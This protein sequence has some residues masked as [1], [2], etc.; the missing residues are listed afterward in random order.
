MLVKNGLETIGAFNI[1]TRLRLQT[2][3][4]LGV[5]LAT[6]LAP[7]MG[8]TT[9]PI[10]L[11][12]LKT[13]E[14]LG[15]E[16]FARSGSTGMVLVV[17][18]DDQVF[19]HGYG[20]NAPQS[21][22]AP[23]S[24]SVVRIC[25]LTKIF[26]SDV[27]TKLVLDKTVRLEDPLQSYA[28]AHKVVPIRNKIITL[29][30]LAT[31]TSGLPR[32]VGSAPRHTPHFTF[33][34]RATR[35]R[36]LPNQYLR[37]TPGSEALYSNVGFDLLGD[38][39]AAAAHKQ[40][41]ALLAE[42]TLQ[43]LDMYGTTYFPNVEQCA[44]LMT[45]AYEEGPCTATEETAGSSGLYS[46]P[47]DMAIWLKYLLGTGGP[48]IPA[49]NPAAQASYLRVADLTREAGLDHAGKPY[50]I[51]LGW[52]HLGAPGDPS[53]IVQKTGG[54]AGFQTYIALHHPSRTAIF[55]AATDGMGE[56]HQNL[57]EGANDV[58]LALAGLPPLPKDAPK[59]VK[60]AKK[61]VRR[62]RSH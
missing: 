57:F 50:G 13:A 47:R 49:Q 31:H 16:L 53:E 4:L 1:F 51:G 18:R 46:T 6:A 7:A 45:G 8:Q 2:R 5:L 14:T 22:Q 61:R 36:W 62:I 35:W 38:A 20:E 28:P 42:R 19:F 29:E 39:L 26:T 44:R 58:L 15:A 33:P 27:L 21:G 12:D 11:P 24:D 41:A 43:P 59:R 3:A 56:S 37:S 30:D 40:Y 52:M 10:A 55:V 54:G 25:S 17:V 32:E 60:A 23:A 48:G 34:D 9:A